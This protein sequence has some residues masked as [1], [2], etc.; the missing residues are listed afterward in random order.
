[1]GAKGE[2]ESSKNPRSGSKGLIERIGSD[3]ML[4]KLAEAALKAA[5]WP[6]EVL[7]GRYTFKLGDNKRNVA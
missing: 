7:V 5:S 3:W 2:L 1:M 4:I 6:T